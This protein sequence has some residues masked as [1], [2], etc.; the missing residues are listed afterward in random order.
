MLEPDRFY[1]SSRIKRILRF[2]DD[3]RD[4]ITKR[5]FDPDEKK[6]GSNYRLWIPLL[7]LHYGVHTEGHLAEILLGD[8]DRALRAVGI[9]DAFILLAA[10]TA[11]LSDGDIAYLMN[12]TGEAVIEARQRALDKVAKFLGWRE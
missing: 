4:G 11:K 9:R 2:R 5:I 10:Y 1:S 3:L 8:C 6:E 7:K 12:T